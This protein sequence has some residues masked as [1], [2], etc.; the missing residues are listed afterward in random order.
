MTTVA[1]RAVRRAGRTA[2]LAEYASLDEVA[3]VRAALHA[4]PIP[5]VTE[6]VVAAR[7]V[8]IRFDPTATDRAS[9]TAALHRL[10]STSTSTATAASAAALASTTT[11]TSA[12]T[13]PTT[14]AAARRGPETTIEVPVVY[15]GPDLDDVAHLAG[16]TT[17]ELV[18]WHGRQTWTSAFCGFAPGFSYLVGDSRPLDVPRRSTSRTTVPAGAVGL[19]GEFSAVYPRSSPGGWQLVGRTDTPMWDIDRDPPAL[20][21]PGARVRFVDAGGTS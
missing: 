21:P 4:L 11:A 16:M 19:A 17:A 1:P 20:L 8:L 14:G 12:A 15:D 2:L 3:A 6:T 5:H 18:A 13:A 7:T 10:A 9:V